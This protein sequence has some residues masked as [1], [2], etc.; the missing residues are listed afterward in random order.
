MSNPQTHW[1]HTSYEFR[2]TYAIPQIVT[3][4][5]Q[6][7]N[8][9]PFVEFDHCYDWGEAEET[10]KWEDKKEDM[11][12]EEVTPEEF[13][14]LDFGLTNNKDKHENVDCPSEMMLCLTYDD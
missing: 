5:R 2:K 7:P 9:D 1:P 14:Y 12:H 6:Q 10:D 13:N 8:S 4:A 3:T 11:R